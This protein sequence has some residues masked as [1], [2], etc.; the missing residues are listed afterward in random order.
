[1]SKIVENATIPFSEFVPLIKD[2][3]GIL[4]EVT[5]IYSNAELSKNTIITL[6]ERIAAAN[7]VVSFLRNNGL[8]SSTYATLQSLVQVLQEM[9]IY[10]KEIAHYNIILTSKSTKS[11]LCKNYES[12]INLLYP[13]IFDVKST[14]ADILTEIT[15]MYNKVQHNDHEKI[16][17]NLM[18]RATAANT[19]V[20]ILRDDNLNISVLQTR[21]VQVL[22]K[23]KK[24]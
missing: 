14:V 23:M 7:V 2:I 4:T 15:N 9:K 24:Y 1:M 16:V 8:Y 13:I 22:Q 18:K 10:S 21:L 17:E 6:M 11:Q 12:I 20:S 19:A 3:A 5:E